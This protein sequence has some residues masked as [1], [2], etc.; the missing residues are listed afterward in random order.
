MIEDQ[1]SIIIDHVKLTIGKEFT[2]GNLA[3]I[4]LNNIEL[5]AKEGSGEMSFSLKDVNIAT[6]E[7]SSDISVTGNINVGDLLLKP[8]SKLTMSAGKEIIIEEE[9]KIISMPENQVELGTD[10]GISNLVIDGRG[11]LC[12]DY[13]KITGVNATGSATLNAGPNSEVLNS[14]GWRQRVCEEVLFADFDAE[15][16]CAG[17]IKQF[18]DKSSGI[19]NSWRWYLDDQ[20]VSEEQNPSLDFTELRNYDLRLEVSEHETNVESFRRTIETIENDLAENEILL[21]GNQLVSRVPAESYQWYLDGQQLDGESNRTLNVV[22]REGVFFVVG[23]NGTCTR[24]SPEFEFRVTSS[25]E[26]L[27]DSEYHLYPNP[28]TEALTIEVQSAYTGVVDISM[29][30]LSG[31]KVYN[32]SSNKNGFQLKQSINTNDLP[33]GLY[34]VRIRQGQSDISKLIAVEQ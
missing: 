24:K 12:F 3:K 11:V 32:Q 29:L 25:D 18:T 17:G 31:R 9:L 2:V 15:T 30:D 28:A 16:V 6:I 19:I 20:L 27:F 23:D 22:G 33:N 26:D 14:M 8:G 4:E 1:S 7:S 13:L 10:G 21:S 34:L 5:D